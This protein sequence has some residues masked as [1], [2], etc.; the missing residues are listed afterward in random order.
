MGGRG[1]SRQVSRFKAVSAVG[2]RAGPDDG[3]GSL[4]LQCM[5][6]FPS[7]SRSLSP[8]RGLAQTTAGRLYP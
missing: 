6:C 5:P 2:S 4:A 7:V 1:R 3:W 8:S